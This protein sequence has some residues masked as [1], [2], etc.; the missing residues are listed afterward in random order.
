MCVYQSVYPSIC[1]SIAL[2]IRRPLRP[3]IRS[4][5]RP[6][7]SLNVLQFVCSAK[8]VFQVGFTVYKALNAQQTKY[9]ISVLIPQSR[10]HST[11]SYDYILWSYLE[12]ELLLVNETFRLMELDF[13]TFSLYLSVLL[14]LLCRFVLRL[15]LFLLPD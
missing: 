13:K 9:L 2:L 8:D 6:S 11:M 7:V 10:H 12:L 14:S 1:Q 4:L 3:S 15:S 5:V